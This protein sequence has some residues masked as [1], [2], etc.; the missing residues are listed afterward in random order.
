MNTLILALPGAED[1]GTSLADQLQCT[2]A[3]VEVHRFPDG[4]QVVRLCA[5]VRGCRVVLAAHLDRPDGKTLPLLF[6]ADAARDLGAREVGLVAP[7]LP[8]MRQDTRF[9]PGEAIT[10]RSYAA[11]LSSSLDFLVTVDPH[12]HRWH[13]LDEIYRIRTRVA[14]AAPAIAAWLARELPHCLVVGPDAESEQWVADVAARIGAPH[15]VLRKE[16][17][18][19][20]EV[21]VQLPPGCAPD[22]RT[23]V[24]LDDILSTGR[25]LATAAQALQGAGWPPPLA[26][27]VH[28]LL[29]QEDL[30]ALHRAGL[31]RIV[32]CDTVPHPTNGIP[33]AAL[34]ADAVRAL[35]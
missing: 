23:P 31:R 12:L 21:R 16:R 15:L 18:G 9:R 8:Y 7:Y 20:R 3:P 6:A 5:D 1:L 26:V 22:G 10:S 32:S 27:V 19:D 34:L 4:E 13:G 35:T 17:L 33:V 24:L 29:Q 25:T 2:A 14:A 30:L 11:L 28:A